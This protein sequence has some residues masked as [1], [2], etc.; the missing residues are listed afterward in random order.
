MPPHMVES[1]KLR[2]NSD[3]RRLAETI[4]SQATS[5]REKTGSGSVSFRFV[6]GASSQNYRYIEAQPICL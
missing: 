3:E 6:G 2:G 5:Y 4:E 1:I